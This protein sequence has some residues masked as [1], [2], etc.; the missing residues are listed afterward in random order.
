MIE[1]A[2]A[3]AIMMYCLTDETIEWIADQSVAYWERYDQDLQ[4]EAMESELA[5][6]KRAAKNILKAIEAGII[7]ETTRSRLLELEAQQS[8]LNAKIQAAKADEV[9]VDRDDLVATL[10][11]LRKGDVEDKQFQADLFRLFLVCVYVYDD[12]TAISSQLHRRP[13]HR[14]NS[15]G[16]WRKRRYTRKP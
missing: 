5:E 3:Q 11:A 4:I 15:S 6:S 9:K 13:Q 8:E 16:S 14:G 12:D 2:V 10:R 1:R 7:T